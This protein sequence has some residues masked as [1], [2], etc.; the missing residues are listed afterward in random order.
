MRYLAAP[1]T[2]LADT[3]LTAQREH[4]QHDGAPDADGL[5]LEDLIAGLPEYAADMRDGASPRPGVLPVVGG[6]ELWWCEATGTG[7]EYVG[8][9]SIRHQVVPALYDQGGQLRVSI[10]PS[11][12]RQGL[13]IE[14]LAAALPIAAAHGI[15]VATLICRN[16]NPAACKVVE[17]VGGRLAHEVGGR[18]WYKVPTR[19][20]AAV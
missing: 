4:T 1:S 16:D 11:R 2:V 20:P 12:R 14:L 3:Y 7:T 17:R 13:G 8:R 10:R 19:Q 5:G 15:E 9:L 6:T 18:R